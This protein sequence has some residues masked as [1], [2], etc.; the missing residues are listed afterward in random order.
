MS[1]TP[2][3]RAGHDMSGPDQAGA[4]SSVV[5]CA[6]RQPGLSDRFLRAML[7]SPL[8][9][10]GLRL[11]LNKML[12][13]NGPPLAYRTRV[14][15]FLYQGLAHN[16]IDNHVYYL[17]MYEPA[18]A[19][20]MRFCVAV[21]PGL[22]QRGFVDIGANTGLFTLVGSGLFAS[23]HAFE[24]YPPVFARLKEHVRL[25]GLETVELYP[26]GLGEH[27]GELP[28]MVPE[29]DNYG[30]GHF[31]SPQEAAAAPHFPIMRGDEVLKQRAQPTGLIK[32]DVEGHEPQVLRG[33]SGLLNVDQPVVI[34]ELNTITKQA[35]GSMQ[36]LMASFPPGYTPLAIGRKKETFSVEPFAWSKKQDNILVVPRHLKAVF[37]A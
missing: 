5:P 31:L 4:A 10:Y 30:T 35:F 15:G 19:A 22:G 12:C 6:D 11:K 14:G 34:M 1:S 18:I 37:N 32:L 24:P 8:L 23:V 33:L 20:A 9:P 36:A 26:L 16:L 27:G 2:E 3:H 25:N 17:G 21:I 7:K 29:S 13:S 28:F